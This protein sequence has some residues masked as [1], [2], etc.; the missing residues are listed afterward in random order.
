MTGL[1]IY[2][3]MVEERHT[4]TEAHPFSTAED[5]IAYARKTAQESARRPED[6]EEAAVPDGW[7]Y[8]ATFSVEGDC[9]WVVASELD[10][11]IQ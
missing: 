8:Y 5:A 4:D 3:A 10:R 1:T 11:G 6:F 2:L 9:V 7:L